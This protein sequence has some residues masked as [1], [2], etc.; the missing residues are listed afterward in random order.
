MVPDKPRFQQEMESLGVQ[1]VNLWDTSHPTCAPDLAEEVSGWRR[2][3]LE[4][5]MHQELGPEDIYRVA[6][7]VLTLLGR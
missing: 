6:D 2:H 5:P 3:C 4:L 7:A 1:T